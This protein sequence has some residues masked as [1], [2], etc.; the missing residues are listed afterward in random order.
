M[1]M[2]GDPN[3]GLVHR[4]LHL[5]WPVLVGQWAV[6][7]FGVIDT[8]MTGHASADD[9]AAMALGSSVYASVLVGLVGVVTALNPIIAQHLGAGHTDEIGKSFV[10]GLWLALFL[11]ILGG[12]AMSFPDAWLVMS[13]VTPAIHDQVASYLHALVFALP[14]ALLF[15]TVYAFNTA[16]SRPKLVM[17][18]NLA[19]LAIKLPLN[20][21]LIYGKLGLPALGAPGCAVA[22]A[23]VMWCSCALGFWAILTD[24]SYHHYAIRWAWPQFVY[25]KELLRL[26]VPTG[27]SYIVEVTSFTFMALL[28]ARLGASVTG[29][30]QITANLAALCYGVPFSLSVAIGTL[31]AQFLGA[32]DAVNARQ[33]VKMGLLLALAIAACL[34]LSLFIFKQQ[35]VALYT[36]EPG[37]ARIALNLI[38]YLIV[39]HVFDAMQ[40]VAGYSLRAYKHAIA[41]MLIYTLSLWG[42]G[43]TGGYWLA[44]HPVIAGRPLGAQGLWLAA[45]VSLAL[46]AIALLFHLRHVAGQAIADAVTPPTRLCAP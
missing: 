10:Q 31:A 24:K 34:S 17:G 12:T 46:A 43:L 38:G 26:G 1:R 20:Y 8:I 25:L 4:I 22:T 30:H 16:V 39:F 44:F 18:I 3:S 11:T 32:G 41:P 40:C 36:S 14:A 7:A 21:L 37:V 5:A 28:V 2:S 33:V 19:A 29:G 42:V 23:T 15:R 13:Q 45:A 27:L 9:L 6:M 35:I